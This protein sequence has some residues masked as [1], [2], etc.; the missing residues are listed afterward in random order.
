VASALKQAGE[1]AAKQFLSVH[2][3]DGD[4]YDLDD[5]AEIG[6]IDELL[7]EVA[8]DGGK[9]FLAQLKLPGMDSLFDQVNDRAVVYA[10]ARAAELVSGVD[11]ATRDDLKSIIADGLADNIGMDAIA[12]NIRDAY[13]FSEDRADLIARTEITM[14]NQQGALQGMKMARGAGVK[15]KK[16]WVPDADACEECQ[17]NEDDGPIDLDDQF[18]SGD[19]A[20]PAHPNCECSVASEVEDEE[21]N[22]TEDDEEDDDSY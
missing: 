12:D 22:E 19:D 13:A 6:G 20:S 1:A 10:K 9:A 2:K 18:S 16:I 15:L 21:G 4:D 11:D 3:D 17:G 5:L 14:A 8:E 7:A